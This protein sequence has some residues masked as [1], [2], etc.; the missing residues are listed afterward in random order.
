MFSTGVAQAESTS[1]GEKAVQ[2]PRAAAEVHPETQPWF[3]QG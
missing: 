3:D 2:E 1:Q